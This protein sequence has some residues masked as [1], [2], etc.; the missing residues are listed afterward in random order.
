MKKHGRNKNGQ[1]RICGGS[2]TCQIVSQMTDP[3]VMWGSTSPDGPDVGDRVAESRGRKGRKGARA[4]EG[5]E[6]SG[7]GE[8]SMSL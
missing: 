3:Q 8:S 2:I 5:T 1:N 6:G 7:W 4:D